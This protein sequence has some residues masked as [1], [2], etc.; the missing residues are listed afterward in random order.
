MQTIEEIELKA[1]LNRA[2]YANKKAAALEK[3]AEQC[4][5]RAQ[6]LTVNWEQ[7]DKGKSDGNVNGTENALLKL[8]EI[9]EKAQAYRVE[10]AEMLA[11]ILARIESLHD[12]DL[13]SV[14]INRYINFYSVDE[15]AE[16][17]HYH[18]QTVKNKVKKAVEKLCTGLY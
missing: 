11:E 17:M 6:G 16:L 4:K 14:L 10:C 1:W 12:P 5:E 15:T 18:P 2:F 9:N 7:N 3:V 8:A 13:E